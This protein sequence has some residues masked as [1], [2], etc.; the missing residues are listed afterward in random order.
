MSGLFQ[1]KNLRTS[2]QQQQ[3]SQTATSTTVMAD[4]T[5]KL[6]RDFIYLK[7]GIFFNESKKYLLEGRVGKRLSVN[8]VA[9]FEEYLDL[10]K[11]PRGRSEL[12]ALYEAITI[13][14][15]YFFRAEQQFEVLEKNIIPELIASK[16]NTL[17]PTIRLWSSASST[18]EEA[19]TMAIIINE[20][21]K[22]LY[23]NVRFQ[24]M[25]SDINNAVLEAARQGLYKEYAIRNVPPNILSKY[26]KKDG[27]VYQLSDEIRKQVTFLNINLFDSA[28]MRSM[29]N[30]DIIFCCNVLI[31]FDIASK[32]QVVSGLYD[33]LSKNGYLLIGYSESL[34]G[35]SKAFKLL[36]LPK[37]MVYKKE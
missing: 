35:I 1:F 8:K 2:A 25:A 26:F 18:G 22:K 13:N 11:S 17:S 33:S 27:V 9:S 12:S 15:T 21:L 10:L 4:D 7:S 36:H 30:F 16:G 32:Q 29:Q 5:F 6:F 34:H 23:P 37:A 24:I 3:T 31:Y 14:E 28:S 20:R 19:Y